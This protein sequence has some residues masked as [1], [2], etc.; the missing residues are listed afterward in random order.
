VGIGGG[1]NVKNEVNP[2]GLGAATDETT[3]ANAPSVTVF[4]T[5]DMTTGWFV[6]GVGDTG[7]ALSVHAEEG[8]SLCVICGRGMVWVWA[9]VVTMFSGWPLLTS[10][11][12]GTGTAN[13][14][15]GARKAI[16]NLKNNIFV[17]GVI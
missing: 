1:R 2:V 14:A 4:G 15:R 11:S 7:K 5:N 8:K 3:S 13:A 12:D 17:K 10:V 16:E 6:T 9:G